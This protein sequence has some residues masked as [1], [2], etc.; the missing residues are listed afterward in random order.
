MVNTKL[1]QG[2]ILSPEDAHKL[3]L[4]E[5]MEKDNYCVVVIS[6]DCDLANNGE[7]NI[8]FIIATIKPKVDSRL[9][10]AQSPRCLHLSFCKPDKTHIHIELKH[11]NKGQIS[12]E[13]INSL[14]TLTY[15]T[16]SEEN[17][18]I[19][20]H[21]LAARY[22]RPAFPDAFETRLRKKIQKETVIRQIKNIF[23][24]VSPHLIAVCFDLGKDRF[25]EL[26]DEEAYFISISIIYDAVEGGPNARV[27]AESTAKNLK[28]LFFEAYGAPDSATDISLEEC[29]AIADTEITL[30]DLR[31]VDL[32]RLEDLSFQ[33]TP[34]STL[35]TTTKLP[36]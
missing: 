23:E 19:L 2:C 3:S 16:I 14:N 28:Q 15:L 31:K 35:I 5:L 33:D 32:W 1:Q 27:I 36:A 4:V 22:G 18:R 7:I 21:W 17:K 9:T 34:H 29:T 11:D 8:E 24:P 20:K 26:D 6:H 13:Q 10:N 25:S 12:K 30:A